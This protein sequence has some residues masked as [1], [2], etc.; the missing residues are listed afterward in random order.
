MSVS[1]KT[2]EHFNQARE[3]YTVIFGG[4]YGAYLGL[5]ISR[6]GLGAGSYADLFW[7]LILSAH[8]VYFL[9]NVGDRLHR[10]MPLSS[11]G[12]SAGVVALCVPCYWLGASLGVDVN[13]LATIVSAWMALIAAE[14]LSYVVAYEFDRRRKKS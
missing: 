2:L 6:N 11:M 5:T 4:M 9:N 1:G 8:L 13:I 7:F 3:A 14:N 10:K 12:Y